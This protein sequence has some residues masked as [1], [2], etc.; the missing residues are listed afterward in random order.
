MPEQSNTPR[1]PVGRPFAKGHDPRRHTFSR[2]ECVRGFWAAHES[3]ISRYPDA[4][5]PDGRHMVVN[6]LPARTAQK[7]ATAHA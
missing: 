3:I 4:I 2:A 6:F 7:G 5:M 1:K